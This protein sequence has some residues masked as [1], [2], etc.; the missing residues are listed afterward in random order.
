MEYLI[1]KFFIFCHPS[2]VCVDYEK[3]IM[4]FKDFKKKQHENFG[5]RMQG[6][7]FESFNISLWTIE[8]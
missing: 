6:E 5:L 1:F 7:T 3:K 4:S 2:T 8:V